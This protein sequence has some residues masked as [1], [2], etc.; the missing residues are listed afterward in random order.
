[1]AA[2]EEFYRDHQQQ[3]AEF[4]MGPDVEG[5]EQHEDGRSVA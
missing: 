5:Q 1:M 3:A 4:A 2:V